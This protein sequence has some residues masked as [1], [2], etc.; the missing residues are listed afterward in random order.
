MWRPFDISLQTAN[1]FYALGWKASVLGA[2]VTFVGVALLFWGTRVRDRDFE[3]Q[4]ASLNREAA[5]FRESAAHAELETARI[6]ERLAPRFMRR[7]PFLAAL[8]NQ[9]K[10]RVEILYLRD[11]PECMEVAQN[12]ALLLEEAH[13]TV[14]S[15]GPLRAND[16][17]PGANNLPSMMTV[18][19]QPSGITVIAHSLTPEEFDAASNRMFGK[20]WTKTPYTVLSYA[21]TQGIG[22]VNGAG[23]AP[24][25]PPEGTLRITVAPKGTAG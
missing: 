21:I 5:Q 22:R 14:L 13:W 7:E 11:D 15:R 25:P 20:P 4:M 3:T 17:A 19:G 8:K 18:G 2:V 1:Q 16:D 12:I 23:G 24:I 6:K 10:G 9:P